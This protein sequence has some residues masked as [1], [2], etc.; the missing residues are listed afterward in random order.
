MDAEQTEI[1]ERLE[2]VLSM[3][4]CPD[5]G[6]YSDFADELL[7]LRLTAILFPPKRRAGGNQEVTNH[8]SSPE[9]RKCPTQPT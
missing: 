9:V 8:N 2:E 4:P 3:I 7:D 5:A 6:C 1:Q